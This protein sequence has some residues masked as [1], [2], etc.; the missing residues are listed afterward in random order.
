MQESVHLVR[1]L[2]HSSSA[3]SWEGIAD[4]AAGWRSRWPCTQQRSSAATLT[5][6]NTRDILLQSMA[7]ELAKKAH[8]QHEVIYQPF[9]ASNEAETEASAAFTAV[10]GLP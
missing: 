7:A 3:P 6:I 4:L 8:F 10:P 2:L 1:G 5:I 9:S